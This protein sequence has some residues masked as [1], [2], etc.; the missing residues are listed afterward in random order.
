MEPESV[1]LS[2]SVAAMLALTGCVTG[3]QI[4]SAWRTTTGEVRA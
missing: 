3:P 1:A 4:V 2:C